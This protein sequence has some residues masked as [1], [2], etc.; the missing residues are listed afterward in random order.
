[1]LSTCRRVL[2][3]TFLIFGRLGKHTWHVSA[4]EAVLTPLTMI[5]SVVLTITFDAF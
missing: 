4:S 2:F 5:I 1:M 3:K